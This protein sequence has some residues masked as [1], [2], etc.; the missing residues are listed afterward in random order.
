MK[1]LIRREGVVVYTLFSLQSFTPPPHTKGMCVGFFFL[2]G[3]SIIPVIIFSICKNLGQMF[4]SGL[5]EKL[6][7]RTCGATYK[8]VIKI[9]D[10]KKKFKDIFHII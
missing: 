6:L 7:L 3:G 8:N 9:G 4:V 1:N 5:Q 2:G 10:F